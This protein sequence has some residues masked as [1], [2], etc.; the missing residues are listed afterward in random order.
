MA[1]AIAAIFKVLV[2]NTESIMPAFSFSLI[3]HRKRGVFRV[4]VVAQWVKNPTSIHEAAVS[5]P[6]LS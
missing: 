2:E 4:P 3:I 6:G 5:I 1:V